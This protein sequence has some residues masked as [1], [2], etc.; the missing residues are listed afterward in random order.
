MAERRFAIATVVCVCAF[1]ILA[2][3]TPLS[4]SPV[5]VSVPDGA[6]F[7][8]IAATVKAD[9]VVTS[10]TLLRIFVMLQGGTRTI[11]AGDY[12]FEKPEGTARVAW[13]LTHGAH[14]L[15]SIRVVVPEGV[16]VLQMSDILSQRLPNFDTEQFL[17]LASGKEGYLFPDT[18]FFM[19][20]ATP[21]TVIE[22]L[23]QQFDTVMSSL[24]VEVA[25]STR[26]V[27]DI[28]TMA[29]I[30][31]EEAKTPEDKHIVA[32]ILWK[33]IDIGMALQVD[34][35]FAYTLGKTSHELT[36]DDLTTDSPYNTYTRVGL[37]P[38]PIS[39][40]GRESLEAA[41]NPEKTDYFYYLTGKDGAMHY[42]KD[43]EEHK[44]NKELYL[45]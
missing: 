41:L 9:H 11:P 44:R 32:G 4:F 10:T 22:T 25:S 24:E 2:L 5:L 17:R 34:A 18:Y 13:R 36:S 42:A 12:L 23:S 31:E 8:E 29:S 16:T 14:G 1:L 37:P 27:P 45:R 21:E 35:T 26:S 30:L 15:Q 20:N 19:V 7:S 28:V 43:F 38:T 39:N 6:S 40:P 3:H 33:R